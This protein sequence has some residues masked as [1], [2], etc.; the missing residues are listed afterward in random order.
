MAGWQWSLYRIWGDS[1]LSNSS[2]IP[3][4]PSRIL[5][6]DACVSSLI[7]AQIVSWNTTL[8]DQ[9]FFPPDAELIKN[10]VPNN[11]DVVDKLIWGGE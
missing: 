3:I 2:G 5:P 9:V 8:M 1:W 11:R 7:H 6:E 10:L 4:T